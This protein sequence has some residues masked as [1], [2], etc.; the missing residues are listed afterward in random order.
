[1][2]V[3]FMPRPLYPQGKSPW[4]PLGRRLGGPQS[5]SGCC[6]EERNSQRSTCG[7]RKSVRRKEM[8]R[9]GFGVGLVYYFSAQAVPLGIRRRWLGEDD[10]NSN[11]ATCP[12]DRLGERN[13]AWD[14]MKN[15]P[16]ISHSHII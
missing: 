8:R 12:L 14:S 2:V 10:L 5:R 7:G 13:R 16:D 3:S 4:F 1:V 15:L 9:S 6:S 11:D